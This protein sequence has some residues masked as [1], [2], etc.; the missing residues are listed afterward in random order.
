MNASLPFS[1]RRHANWQGPQT[2]CAGHCYIHM[3]VYY[4]DS[5]TGPGCLMQRG[6]RINGESCMYCDTCTR[7]SA[8]MPKIF[9]LA[10]P[11]YR[12]GACGAIHTQDTLQDTLHYTWIS[13]QSVSVRGL[14]EASHD[15]PPPPNRGRLDPRTGMKIRNFSTKRAINKCNWPGASSPVSRGDRCCGA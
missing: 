7:I 12:N 9:T 4:S 11:G 15:A 3:Y 1:R 6:S 5:L 13:D 10:A 8:A 2:L 14:V